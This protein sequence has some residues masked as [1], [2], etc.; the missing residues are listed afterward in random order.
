MLH[1]SNV[2]SSGVTLR[3][4]FGS[5][6][7]QSEESTRWPHHRHGLLDRL[8]VARPEICSRAPPSSCTRTV[9]LSCMGCVGLRVRIGAART[10]PKLLSVCG[11]YTLRWEETSGASVL[12]V[13]GRLAP[14]PGPPWTL[15]TWPCGEIRER[16]LSSNLTPRNTNGWTMHSVA[17]T[18][19]LWNS[20]ACAMHYDFGI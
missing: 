10:A 7:M 1:I 5:P 17:R 18:A 19:T 4:F 8:W 15:D 20:V 3:T 13:V 12:L 6:K 16:D 14:Q 9:S 11:N 2:T